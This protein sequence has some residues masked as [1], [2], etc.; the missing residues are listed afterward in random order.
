MTSGKDNRLHG[1]AV[2]DKTDL[3]RIVRNHAG[4]EDTVGDIYSLTVKLDRAPD[5]RVIEPAVS[6]LEI[7]RNGP[8]SFNSQVLVK[9][10]YGVSD[11]EILASVAKG[12]GEGVKFRDEKIEFDQSI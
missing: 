4:E 2:I 5:I 3:Y 10:D 6:S 11:V 8:A 9:D 1:G 12:S 7:P